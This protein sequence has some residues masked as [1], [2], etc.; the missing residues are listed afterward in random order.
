MIPR[1]L[2]AAPLLLVG[3]QSP[4]DLSPGPIRSAAV[5]EA[6]ILRESNTLRENRPTLVRVPSLDRAAR[7]QAQA[8][9][10]KRQLSHSA[11]P[12]TLRSRT[13]TPGLVGE[14]IARIP[15]PSA[16]GSVFVDLWAR[17]RGHRRNLMERKFCR[18]GIGVVRRGGQTY[19]AQVFAE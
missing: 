19:A 5:I 10:N 8:M 15:D 3:C 16:R 12:G 7:Q 17:S 9:A 2:L 11:A 13:G 1:A 14:N 6:N 18:T 4:V